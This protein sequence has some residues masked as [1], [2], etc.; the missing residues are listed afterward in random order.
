MSTP[1]SLPSP[2]KCLVLVAIFI[3][4]FWFVISGSLNSS[5]LFTRQ[6]TA[7]P[8]QYMSVLIS[9]FVGAILFALCHLIQVLSSVKDPATFLPPTTEFN[10]E[11]T[12]EKYQSLAHEMYWENILLMNGK[13]VGELYE[14]ASEKNKNGF[15][16]AIQHVLA[17][18]TRVKA[19]IAVKLA[20]LVVYVFLA[21]TTYSAYM[22]LIFFATYALIFFFFF[23]VAVLPDLRLGEV[24]RS[25]GSKK[26]D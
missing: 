18:Q 7:L 17:V 24:F 2:R 25:Y 6:Y 22:A 21:P 12:E 19:M 9:A 1:S 5:F 10:P 20:A 15:I 11:D 14:K 3:T 8:P 4:L 23:S 16:N 13:E 26:P